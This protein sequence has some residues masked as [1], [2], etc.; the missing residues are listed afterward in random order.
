MYISIYVHV[1]MYIYIYIY[2]YLCNLMYM[3]IYIYAYI[4]IYIYV[5]MFIKTHEIPLFLLCGDLPC[6]DHGLSTEAP[7]FPAFRRSRRL[8]AAEVAFVSEAAG[9]KR[10]L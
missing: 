6:F 10:C 4:H 3:Y 2:I 9:E 1:Y 5:H 8:R 7:N